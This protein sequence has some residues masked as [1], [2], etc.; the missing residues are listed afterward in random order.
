MPELKTQQGQDGARHGLKATRKQRGRRLRKISDAV[1]CVEGSKCVSSH[2]RGVST[3]HV[4]GLA[5]LRGGA[6][7]MTSEASLPAA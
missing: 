6:K 4:S 7:M 5:S 2:E 3:K 1:G